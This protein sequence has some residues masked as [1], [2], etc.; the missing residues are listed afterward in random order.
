MYT[1]YPEREV[2]LDVGPWPLN[3][4]RITRTEGKGDWEEPKS[5]LI[6]FR[7]I[8]QSIGRNFEWF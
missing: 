7:I 2:D 6:S 8:P 4:A 5:V 1:I 3:K